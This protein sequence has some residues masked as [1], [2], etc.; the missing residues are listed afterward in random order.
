MSDEPKRS[1]LTSCAIFAAIPFVVIVGLVIVFLINNR[2]PNIHVPTPKMPKDNAW[3]YFSKAGSLVK[4]QGPLSSTR[5]INSWTLPEYERFMQDNTAAIAALRLGLT[6]PYMH[7]PVRDISSLSNGFSH[8]A[9]MREMA[10]VLASASMYYEKIGQ[11]YS[12]V[13]TRLDAVEMGGIV[14]RGGASSQG[15]SVSLSG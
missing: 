4:G 2:P 14:P 13:N 11:P 10:R 6:K 7:P 9:R 1:K 3:D 8:Y 5:P 15:W 12:A